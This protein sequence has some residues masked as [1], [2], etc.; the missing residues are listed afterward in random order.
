MAQ[1]QSARCQG[2]ARFQGREI[3]DTVLKHPIPGNVSAFHQRG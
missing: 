3:S 1:T 2:I